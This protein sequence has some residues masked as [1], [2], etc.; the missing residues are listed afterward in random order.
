M[1]DVAG[2]Q[3]IRYKGW[4]IKQVSQNRVYSLGLLLI[5]LIAVATALW[6]ST[7]ATWANATSVLLNLSFDTIVAVGMMLLL[8]SG[9]FDLSVGSLLGVTA[10]FTSMMLLH[11][12][13]IFFTIVLALCVAASFGT[14]NGLVIAK[15]GVNPMIATLAMM[16]I[17]R[18]VM[19]LMTADVFALPDTF[20]ALGRTK[21]FDIQMPFYVAI[22]IVCIFSV[23]VSNL[24]FFKRYY[25]IGG[26][27]KAALLS[28]IPVAK[29]K[30]ISFIISA[31]LAGIA[32][33][34]LT[35]R[36]GGSMVTFGTGMELRVITAVILGGASLKGGVGLIPGAFLGTLFMALVNNI[37]IIANVSVYWQQIVIGI[38]LLT[39][40]SVDVLLSKSTARL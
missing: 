6:P 29:M 18:G 37:M 17:A 19:L 5:L 25:Y 21:V 27:E 1:A 11:G 13:P 35:A 22:I 9:M 12:M 15:I 14:V 20:L 2:K 28:G 10:G 30:I 4:L 32:G 36:M 38:I 26:N 34:L 3:N 24:A 7:F 8:I 31:V 39:A 40:V 16:G 23:L 33:I